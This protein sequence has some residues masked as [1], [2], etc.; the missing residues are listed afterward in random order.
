MRAQKRVTEPH[1]EEMTHKERPGQRVR[2]S[3]VVVGME[4]LQR[5]R[6]ERV[7]ASFGPLKEEG[8]YGGAEVERHVGPRLQAPDPF[9]SRLSVLMKK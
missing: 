6:K 8:S 9:R 7:R 3:R 5:L 2:I 4:S 1:L